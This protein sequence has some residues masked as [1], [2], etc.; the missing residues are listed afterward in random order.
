[1]FIIKK[2]CIPDWH[3]SFLSLLLGDSPKLRQY[4]TVLSSRFLSTYNISTLAKAIYNSAP[5]K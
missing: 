1:M 5:K 4:R 3:T 2:N